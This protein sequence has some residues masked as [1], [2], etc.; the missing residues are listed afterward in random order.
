ML[1]KFKIG[2][3]GMALMVIVLIIIAILPVSIVNAGAGHDV[4]K[5][6][7]NDMKNDSWVDSI[8]H[9]LILGKIKKPQNAKM[10]VPPENVSKLPKPTPRLA[11]YPT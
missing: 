4:V 11:P 1:K 7:N 5:K 10:Y 6:K 2:V 3:R 8:E 9:D